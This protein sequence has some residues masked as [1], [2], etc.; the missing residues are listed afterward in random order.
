M[1]E[2]RDSCEKN[3]CENGKFVSGQNKPCQTS[4]PVTITPLPSP[5]KFTNSE[6]IKINP[7]NFHPTNQVTSYDTKNSSRINGH[8]FSNSQSQNP[9]SPATITLKT[10]ENPYKRKSQEGKHI[11]AELPPSRPATLTAC[12]VAS[13]RMMSPTTIARSVSE[14]KTSTAEMRILPRTF[15][16]PT[17]ELYQR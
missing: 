11:M 12:T 13:T 2:Q 10:P 5:H 7:E 15:S 3:L 4:P 17:S 14:I 9:I 16:S 8:Y 6:L 1:R